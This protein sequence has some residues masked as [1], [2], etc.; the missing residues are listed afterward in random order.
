MARLWR[1]FHDAAGLGPGVR[2]ALD[3]DEAHHVR[4]VLRLQPGDA[5]AVFD[6]RGGEWSATIAAGAP[7]E[8]VVTLGT[9][10]DDALEA[11]LE[12]TLWQG[13]SRS[14]RFELAV[15]KATELGARA[16][17]ALECARSEGR[18]PDARRLERY[19]RVA[20]EAC[21]QSGR[22]RLPELRYAVELP[23]PPPGTA[24]LLLDTAGAPPLAAVAGAARPAAV[25]IG[26]GPEGGLTAAERAAALAAGWTAVGLGPRTLRTETAG[27]V[28]VALVLHRW[29]DLGA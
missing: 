21:K 16:I 5:L 22:R 9:P 1:A 17:V 14:E 29:A 7:R 2:I 24:A 3:P 12:V 18:P 4:K 8:V 15:Q 20:I 23:P 13:R 10:R 19:R 28:A 26:V 6:G 25:W 11:P 27:I